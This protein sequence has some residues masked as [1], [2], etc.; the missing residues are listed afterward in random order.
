MAI[1]EKALIKGEKRYQAAVYVKDNKKYIYGSWQKRKRDAKSDENR[2]QYDL[3]SGSYIKETNKTFDEAINIYFEL[4][5]SDRLSVGTSKTY[6]SLYNSHLKDPFGFR[7]LTSIKPYEIQRIWKNK[8]EFLANSTIIKLHTLMNNVYKQFI[9]WEEIKNNP[10]DKVNKPSIN[11]RTA[12]IWTKKEAHSFL[13]SARE[14]QSYMVFWLGLNAGMR[15][16]ECLGLTWDCVDFNNNCIVVKQQYSRIE[17]K[18]VHHTKTSTSM[19]EIDLSKSQMAILLDHKEKQKNYNL[20][21][22]NVCSNELGGFI[23]ERNIRRAKKTICMRANVKEITFHELRH[24]HASM[25]VDLNEPIK[26][27]Q[28][29]LGHADVKTTLN[30][31]VHTQKSHHRDT[32]ERFS[33]FFNE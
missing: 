15:L 16:G 1:R 5:T 22:N 4:T 27:V 8:Q 28:E 24:T 30:L 14:Y 7:K 3:H 18:I 17:K 20:K 9:Q 11:Y 31:Y 32:A 2:I 23:Q 13:K 12:N 25:L 19:R 29:R 33:V 10:L 21:T 6:K 26:Y